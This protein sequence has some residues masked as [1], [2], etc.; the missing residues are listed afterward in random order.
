MNLIMLNASLAVWHVWPPVY[1]IN[2]ECRMFWFANEMHAARGLRM[3]AQSVTCQPVITHCLSVCNTT[4]YTIICMNMIILFHFTFFL[5][6]AINE[7]IQNHNNNYIVRQASHGFSVVC[8]LQLF[9]QRSFNFV[10]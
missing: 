8:G 10:L 4:R 9:V 3:T 2:H 1:E 5:I 7:I 6:F